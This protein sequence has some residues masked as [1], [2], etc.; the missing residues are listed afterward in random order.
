MAKTFS[1][2]QGDTL[3]AFIGQCLDENG[4]PVPTLGST[5]TFRMRPQVPG[6]KAPISAAAAWLDPSTAT[7]KYEWAVGNTDTPGL[8]YADFF[9]DWGSGVTESFP[10]DG[11]T[12]VEVLKAA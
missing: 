10:N 9:V 2:K 1:I 7:A 4:E 3:P 12:V 5:V 8:Y 11:Y 6:V